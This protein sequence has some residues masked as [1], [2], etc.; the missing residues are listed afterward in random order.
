M[1]R[2]LFIVIAQELIKL[3]L[4]SAFRRHLDAIFSRVDH[5]L[6]IYISRGGRYANVDRAISEAIGS[7]TGRPATANEQQLVK[8][9][10]DPA[11]FISR[12]HAAR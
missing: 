1:I 5:Q 2:S 4:G 3:A 7:V 10:F 11:R 9:L 6:A 8:L 12:L